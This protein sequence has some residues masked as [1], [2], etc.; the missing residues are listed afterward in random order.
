MCIPGNGICRMSVDVELND[1]IIGEAKYF[2]QIFEIKYTDIKNTNVN[3]NPK[4]AL[5]NRDFLIKSQFISD[6]QMKIDFNSPFEICY[7]VIAQIF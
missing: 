7:C 6:F 2:A 1:I 5:D 4:N 3:I